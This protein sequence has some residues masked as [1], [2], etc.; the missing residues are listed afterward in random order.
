[1]KGEKQAEGGRW[2]K[3]DQTM[4]PG[5]VVCYMEKT[6]ALPLLTAYDKAKNAARSLKRLY[7]RREAMM[8]R[9]VTEY[10]AALEFRDRRA[11]EAREPGGR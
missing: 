5:K 8:Q 7:A 6:I 10:R 9:L 3:I 4:R 1:M 11:T 2:G